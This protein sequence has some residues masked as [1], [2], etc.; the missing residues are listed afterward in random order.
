MSA[1][2]RPTRSF[3]EHVDHV[4]AMGAYCKPGARVVVSGSGR[5]G[6]V[7][8][9]AIRHNGPKIKWDDPKFGVTEGRVMLGSLEPEGEDT[10]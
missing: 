9:P 8:A 10:T 1:T 5:T 3:Y 7:V 2:K 6:T 4:K